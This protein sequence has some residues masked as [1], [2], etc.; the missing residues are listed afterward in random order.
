MDTQPSYANTAQIT[1][2]KMLALFNVLNQF[3]LHQ[4]WNILA[5]D[6]AELIALAW[7]RILDHYNIPAAAYD[8]LYIRAMASRTKRQAQGDELHTMAVSDLT[9]EWVGPYGYGEEWR[10]MHSPKQL[11]TGQCRICNNTGFQRIV[12]DGHPGVIPC[13]HQPQ[14]EEKVNG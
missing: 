6:E 10:K 13:K 14:G 4:G 7:I 11:L 9:A 1:P 12:K 2:D 3:R 5:A 8:A